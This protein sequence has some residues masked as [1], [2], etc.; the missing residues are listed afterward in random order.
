MY[1]SFVVL[2]ERMLELQVRLGAAQPGGSETEDIQRL[3]ASTDLEI[4]Q[5]VCDLYGLTDEERRVVGVV[6]G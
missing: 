2:V 3:V 1:D 5:L 6:N 4:D